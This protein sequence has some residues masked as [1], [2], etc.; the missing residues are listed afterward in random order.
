MLKCPY[1]VD[2]K[3]GYNSNCKGCSSNP[4]KTEMSA[5]EFWDECSHLGC[6]DCIYCDPRGDMDNITSPCKRIDHKHIQFAIPWFKSYDCGQRSGGIC[7]DFQPNCWELWLI[8][9]WKPEFK[10]VY[11]D[12]TN[13]KYVGLCLDKDQS[14]RYY[15]KFEDFFNNTFKNEDGSLKWV[16]KCYYKRT[17]IGFG[18]KLIW[19]Y[20][21]AA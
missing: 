4:N 16:K 14:I 5:E 19:E 9:H 12:N 15:V 2:N 20:N 6:G 13:T 8:R 17:R 21:N 3:C 18:Y 11:K 7:N 10:E 1:T